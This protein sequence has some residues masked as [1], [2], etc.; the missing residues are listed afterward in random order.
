[1]LPS[2]STS[3]VVSKTFVSPLA[4]LPPWVARRP[5]GSPARPAARCLGRFFPHGTRFWGDSSPPGQGG[6]TGRSLLLCPP[7]FFVVIPSLL[8]VILDIPSFLVFLPSLSSWSLRSLG[9]G[10][11]SWRDTNAINVDQRA[12]KQY[13]ISRGHLSRGSFDLLKCFI[14]PGRVARS[15]PPTTPST[16]ARPP[17][18]CPTR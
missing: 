4:E 16:W 5:D 6:R 9:S 17:P 12:L 10:D 18:A 11:M 14:S 8:S 1:M 15:T 2:R 7:F 3:G 13:W